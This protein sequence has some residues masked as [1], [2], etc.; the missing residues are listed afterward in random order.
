M[1]SVAL[2]SVAG[3]PDGVVPMSTIGEGL[4]LLRRSYGVGPGSLSVPAAG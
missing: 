3:L 2:R 4:Q 1:P